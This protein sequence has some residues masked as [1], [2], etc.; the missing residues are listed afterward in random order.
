MGAGPPLCGSDGGASKPLLGSR[1]NEL[2]TAAVRDVS[3]RERVEARFR[4]LLESA[5]DAI[6][7]VNGAG[8]IPDISHFRAERSLISVHPG[9][10][11]VPER[12]R[13]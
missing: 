9:F 12:R 10:P 4:G 11:W 3:F 1:A 5:P 13:G 2:V 8:R 6:V 7:I